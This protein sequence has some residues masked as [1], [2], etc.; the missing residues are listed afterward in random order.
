[1]DDGYH[2][3]KEGSLFDIRLCG[4]VFG[5]HLI[6]NFLYV[7]FLLELVPHPPDQRTCI[8]INLPKRT[9]PMRMPKTIKNHFHQ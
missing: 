9:T 6:V 8:N 3:K 1:M 7:L 5:F 4:L 2:N